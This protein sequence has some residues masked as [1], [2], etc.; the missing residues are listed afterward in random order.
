MDDASLL[1]GSVIKFFVKNIQPIFIEFIKKGTV[2]K[3]KTQTKNKLKYK[4]IWNF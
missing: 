1:W 3:D 2:K 4:Q